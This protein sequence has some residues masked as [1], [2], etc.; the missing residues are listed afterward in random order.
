VISHD[1]SVSGPGPDARDEGSALLHEL[2]ACVGGSHVL[3]DPALLEGYTR[4]W[5]GRYG[6][7]ALAVVRPGTAEEVAAV[8]SACVRFGRSVIPQGGN[9]GLV[10]GAVPPA[11]VPE[12]SDLPVVLSTRRLTRLDPVDPVSGQVT[13]GAGVTLGDLQRHA[14]A[15]G[16]EYGVDLAA[17]DAATVGG[18]VATNAGGI[19]VVAYGMT[20]MQ[21]TGV[22]AALPLPEPTIVDH[23]SGLAKDNTGYDLGGLLTGSEGTLAVITAVRL[24]LH[25]PL[26]HTSLLLVG[27]ASYAEAMRLMHAAVAPGA[28][29]KSAEVIDRTGIEVAMELSGAAWPLAE[30]HA[31]TLLLEVADG[32]DGSGF[33]AEEIGELDAVLAVE[34]AD[35]RRLWAYREL[36]SEAYSTYAA[37]RGL[38]A[39]HKLDISV[40]MA[41][42]ASCCDLITDRLAACEGVQVFGVFG[43]LGDGNIHV[44]L[45]GPQDDDY[46]SDELVLG[47]VGE[48]GGSVSA[49]HGIGRVKVGWL[50]VSRSAAEIAVMRATK[51]AWDPHGIL[52][53]GVLFP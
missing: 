31:V 13:V 37:V 20:R 43:H 53:P 44:E 32:G 24:R 27:V 33:V 49:E 19:H 23:L 40:P 46:R 22:Q 11:A 21:V 14:A 35:Q 52:N 4:D 6:G 17:R 1:S 30:D 29:V 42:L 34:A 26:G 10:A 9:T 12:G 3:T 28:R 7:P 50:P 48:Y 15:A 18:T 39:A 41:N 5:T 38:P 16:W 8:L 36:Q 45:V 2:R 47:V 25:R 51:A